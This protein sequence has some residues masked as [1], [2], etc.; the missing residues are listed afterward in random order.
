M[1]H[2]H[3]RNI[4]EPSSTTHRWL[5]LI[6]WT[7]PPSTI[8]KGLQCCTHLNITIDVQGLLH[9]L[10]FES[11]I[12]FTVLNLRHVAQHFIS[13]WVHW[14]ASRFSPLLKFYIFH[15][16]AL[17]AFL[18]A[19]TVGACFVSNE[20]KYK[21]GLV[22]VS[23]DRS[24]RTNENFVHTRVQVVLNRYTK[25]LPTSPLHLLLVEWRCLHALVAVFKSYVEP[26]SSATYSLSYS[27]YFSKAAISIVLF[28]WI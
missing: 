27:G 11:P 19:M 16:R 21:K 24:T 3:Y 1:M 17:T 7:V 20:G 9:K 25:L 2:L 8:T 4:H 26:R 28:G 23:Q 15:P 5:L 13:S 22:V 14:P 10:S 12:T 6:F 18:P